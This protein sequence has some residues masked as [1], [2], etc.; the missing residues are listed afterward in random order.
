[1]WPFAAAAAAVAVAV[2]VALLH[3]PCL[4]RKKAVLP[5]WLLPA[6][7]DA[8]ARHH[9]QVQQL[10]VRL[11]GHYYVLAS[12]AAPPPPVEPVHLLAFSFASGHLESPDLAPELAPALAPELVL[13]LAPEL[14]PEQPVAF[15]K[16]RT[17]L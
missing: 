2:A 15:A 12:V 4:H 3:K 7:L 14:V 10:T 6:C 8:V 17:H 9:L 16:K 5:V 11:P 13:E 1:M